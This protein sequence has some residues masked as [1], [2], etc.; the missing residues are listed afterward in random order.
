MALT[1]SKIAIT[2]TQPFTRYFD[3]YLKTTYEIFKIT[4]L[5][6]LQVLSLRTLR[7]ILIDQ[8]P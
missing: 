8:E 5:R 6:P 4:N 7:E 1:Q 2:T 3:D